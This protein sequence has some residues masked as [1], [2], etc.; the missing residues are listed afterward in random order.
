M[1]LKLTKQQHIFDTLFKLPNL[2][3]REKKEIIEQ[4]RSA[5]KESVINSPDVENK[6]KGFLDILLELNEGGAGFSDLELRNEVLATIVEGSET[7]AVIVCNSLVLL[8]MH[9]DIQDKVYD[10]IYNVFG[11]SDRTITF[12]DTF[13]LEY[14][15]QVLKES[16]RLFPVLPI[17]MRQLDGNIKIASGDVT[18]P[19][20]ATCVVSA[21]G[22][23]HLPELYPDPWTFNPDNFLPENIAK[24]HKTNFLSFSGGLRGCIGYKYG[25]LSMKIF[26]CNILRNFSIHTDKKF[27]DMK[28]KFDLI[29][30]SVNG[31]PVTIRPRNKTQTSSQ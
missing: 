30:R 9:Q 10:E 8:A 2:V 12:E 24:R 14:L 17:L 21:Y 27:N 19:K 31:Y 26:V 29:M 11:D 6:N 13:Q 7:S 18:L 5:K 25:M 1:Y 22:L 23:H 16:S 4:R 28:F 15:D 20:G 3:I